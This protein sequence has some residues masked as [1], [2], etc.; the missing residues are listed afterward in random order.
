MSSKRARLDE[1]YRPV[2]EEGDGGASME[3][4]DEVLIEASASA[5]RAPGAVLNKQ[6]LICRPETFQLYRASP[7]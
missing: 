3:D 6:N 5:P 7:R 1:G 4:V 2:S